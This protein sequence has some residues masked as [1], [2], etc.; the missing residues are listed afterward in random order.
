TGDIV[1][2]S[3]GGE[4]AI[5]G[6]AKDT[7]I[8]LGGENVEPEPIEEHLR[9]S[10]LIEDVMVVGQDRRYLAALIVLDTQEAS[11][12]MEE[13]GETDLYDPGDGVTP[14]RARLAEFSALHNRIRQD[15]AERVSA[16]AGYRLHEQVYRFTLIPRA[17]REP[18]ELT[19]TRKKRRRV[20]EENFRQTI[21][22]MFT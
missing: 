22:G 11:R 15:I 1:A 3:R 20:I 4:I 7:I 14:S 18:D 2:R 9:G 5:I 21:N 8:L 17:F 16:G 19:H 6:R 12:F 10:S 13:L